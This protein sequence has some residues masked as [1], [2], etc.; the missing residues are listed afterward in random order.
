[1]AHTISISSIIAYCVYHPACLIKQHAFAEILWNDWEIFAVFT[2]N[3]SYSIQKWK[4]TAKENGQYSTR[5]E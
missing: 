3:Q 2:S 5:K 4:G 1:M